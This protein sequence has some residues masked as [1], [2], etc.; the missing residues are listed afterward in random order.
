MKRKT[1]GFTLI[2]LL[3]VIAIIGI[4]AAILIPVT[5]RVRDQ[6]RTAA[7]KS[8]QRQAGLGLLMLAGDQNGHLAVFRQG[9]GSGR[10]GQQLINDGYLDTGSRDVLFCPSWDPTDYYV[11]AWDWRTYGFNLIASEYTRIY[12]DDGP[13][14]FAINT[15]AIEEPSSY[16]LLADSYHP[17][18]QNQRFRISDYSAS[19]LDGLHLR[20]NDT[21]NLFF[22]D[23][24]VES[25]D[26]IRL[27]KIGF[28]TVYAEDG[29]VI[30]FPPPP[31]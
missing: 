2:E 10:W 6:A 15:E 25:A 29:R 12:N 27:A 11:G 24:H 4:L 17:G 3:T 30:R 26:A 28:K 21:A 23:G 9:N 13:E 14:M 1:S 7:C 31:R 19:A 16:F 20:H 5:A 18:N 22:L 8:N